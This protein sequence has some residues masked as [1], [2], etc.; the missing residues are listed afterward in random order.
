MTE[1]ESIEQPN[2]SYLRNSTLIGIVIAVVYGLT[3]RLSFGLSFESHW[4]N[5]GIWVMT[6][7]FLFGGP[8]VI[9]LVTVNG[10]SESL[11][12]KVWF[13]FLGP[14]LPTSLVCALAFLFRIEGAICIVM[15]LPIML[16]GSSVGG[17]IVGLYARK[18][19]RGTTACIAIL[20]FL[21]APAQ[22][23]L[24]DPLQFRTVSS[25]I[26]I[27]A[28][29]DMVWRN[30]ARVPPISPTEL[31]P[32]WTHRIGFPRP[33]E[34]TLSYEGVGGVRHA[35]FERG[36]LFIETV[37]A[38]EPQH[39]LAFGIRADTAHIPPTTLDEHVTIGGRYFDVLDGEYSL[40]SLP[41]GDILLHLTSRQRL[42]T[43]FNE[44]AGFWTDAVMQ[45]LQT[46]ILK[47]IQHRCEHE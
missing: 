22:A 30:I 47:V 29:A 21:L 24:D 8:L 16:F 3:L 20:P 1:L 14:W 28:P 33:V 36:L 43:G 4:P 5:S 31:Q 7:A 13:W 18:L 38:W 39:R 15:G 12:K 40:E 37:T 17:L 9:G 42:S 34:A 2:R 10:A 19:S 26:R 45:N 44:Y 6:T 41:N 46:S 32:N 25:E 23:R 11:K 35:S 27:H